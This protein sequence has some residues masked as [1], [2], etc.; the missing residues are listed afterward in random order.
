M[1]PM[2]ATGLFEVGKSIIARLF[3]DPE[4]KARA[5]LQLLEMQQS[6]ELKQVETQLSAIIAEAQSADKWTSR[7]RPS[8]LYVCYILILSAIPMGILHAVSPETAVSVSEGFRAWLHAIPEEIVT[9]M[10]VGYLGYTG[11]RSVDK[12]R[13][14]E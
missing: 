12:R 3:P 1:T 7:A 6:G 13:K 5:E 9:L 11:A 2:I 4:Q 8:F 14:R 10:G